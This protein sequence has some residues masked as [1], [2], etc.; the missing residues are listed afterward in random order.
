MLNK[1]FNH[2]RTSTTGEHTLI[3]DLV[4][5]TI[6]TSGLHVRF[7]K[8]NSSNADTVF[9]DAE[10]ISYTSSYEIEMWLDDTTGFAGMGDTVTRFGY[11]VQDEC[12]LTVAIDRFESVVGAGEKP[13]LGDLIH[14]PLSNQMYQ[15]IWV[16]DQEPFF[17]LTKQF[18]YLINC[19]LFQYANQD[20]NTGIDAIDALET[21]L[22]YVI[23]LVL[24]A[25][26]TGTFTAG[27]TVYQ[28]SVGS[29]TA[30]AEVVSWTSGTRTLRVMNITGT[31]ATN[32]AITDGTASWTIE[33]FDDQT[34]PTDGFAQNLEFETAE[35]GVVDFTESNPF[36]TF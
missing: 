24:E 3:Q 22:S 19:Q 28:G 2:N 35:T 33:S 6:Q 29:E 36:G 14:L 10:D 17:T 30:K 32:I 34:M 21:N 20:F 1:F 25:G 9:G 13:K 8:R 15:I 4:R 27:T 26:G 18:V 16:E 7:I 31:F 5:E 12:A 23:D 11:E